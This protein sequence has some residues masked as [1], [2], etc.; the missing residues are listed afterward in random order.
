MNGLGRYEEALAAA[1]DGERG[2]PA[3][4]RRDVGA[5]RADRGVRPGPGSTEVAQRGLARLDEQTRGERNRLGARDPRQV[6][7]AAER[8][9]GSGAPVP[10][11]DRP[12]RAHPAPAGS[13][14]RAPPLRGVAAPRGP[15]RRRPRA[16]AHGARR[17]GRDRHGGVRRARP[18]RAAGHRGAGTQ[19]DGRDTAT[20]SRRRSS[21]S[22]GSP[23]TGCPT[24][25]SAPSCSSARGPSSGTSGRCSPSSGFR[26][27]RSC[28]RRCP[29]SGPRSAPKV[30]SRTSR[31]PD[32]GSGPLGPLQVGEHREHPAV[33]VGA[34]AAAR[35]SRRCWRCGPRPSC[36]PSTADRRS[37]GSIGP[38]AIK[39]RTSRSR[40]VRSSSGTRERRPTSTRDDRGI[41][42][43]AALRDPPDRVGEVVEIRD[44]VLEQVAD[45]AR[46]VA[47]QAQ[48]ERRLDVLG[49]DEDA[50]GRPVLRADRLRGAQALVRVGRWHP[51]VDDRDVREML[52]GRPQERVRVADLGDHL[53]PRVD[54]ETRDALRARGSKSSAR[55][56]RRVIGDRPMP[57][58]RPRRSAPWG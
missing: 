21:R 2:H 52:A 19:A 26:R 7:R 29:R 55:T 3:A 46:A 17:A 54:Q 30:Q 22:P 18:S 8:G 13:R 42:D 43:R 35:A 53:E 6:G 1:V 48:R 39:A 33:V 10:R 37:P 31:D 32:E 38:P 24:R 50:D 44:P 5:E 28:A 40:S 56:S 15:A 51:D 36:A 58:S 45:P 57:G 23:A 25:R 20:S 9:R 27:A 12:P 41:D 49:Q 47:H 34:R 11:S 14:A 4:A 16:A